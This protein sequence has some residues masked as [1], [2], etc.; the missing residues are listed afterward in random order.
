[1]P[2]QM[3]VDFVKYPYPK[4]RHHVSANSYFR[5]AELNELPENYPNIY[6][7]IDWNDKFINGKA[8]DML[9]IGC[10]K[11]T[12]LLDMAEKC[13]DKN[14]LGVEIRQPAVKWINQVIRGEQIS[15]ASVIWYN[16]LNGMQFIEPE[17]IENM[18]YLF[19]DPWP[20]H[21][22]HKRRAFSPLMLDI[23]YRML[24]PEGTLHL[25]TDVD[26]VDENHRKVIDAHGKFEYEILEN[27]DKWQLPTTNKENFC[28]RKDIPVYRL[29]CKKK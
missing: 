6:T 15:N 24:K 5:I 25:A 17:S 10:G 7:Y 22:Q 11:G 26:Y 19:P 18:F 3:I 8:P 28:I 16:V 2:N 13:P 29:L 9:D 23:L 21:K 4:M 12:F 20:K 14:I 1:M 27:K